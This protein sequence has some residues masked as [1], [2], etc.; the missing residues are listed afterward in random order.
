MNFT[1][2]IEFNVLGDERGSLVALE[3]MSDIPF[4]I[5]RVYYIFGTK[6]NVSRGFHAHKELEQVAVCVRGS[7]QMIMDD[8]KK[9]ERILL[10]SPNKG[11]V[12][13]TMQWHEM[14]EFSEDCI[15]LV[16]ANDIY[17]E[18]DYIRDYEEFLKC[19]KMK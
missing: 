3:E 7:C 10:N 13:G 12:I 14:H 6:E 8:G 11:I 9:R 1:N 17:R 5:K 19:T 18:S 4:V 2:L 15:L 16:L